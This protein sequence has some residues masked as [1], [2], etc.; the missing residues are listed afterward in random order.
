VTGLFHQT[1]SVRRKKAWMGSSIEWP[2]S[3]YL[4][5]L[6]L[7]WKAFQ[8]R[9]DQLVSS[10]LEA[11]KFY[12]NDDDYQLAHTFFDWGKLGNLLQTSLFEPRSPAFEFHSKGQCIIS[13]LF[14][15]Q[16]L[17]FFLQFLRNGQPT[18]FRHL[19]AIS[20]W[21]CQACLGSDPVSSAPSAEHSTCGMSFGL[22]HL[23]VW[24]SSSCCRSFLYKDDQSRQ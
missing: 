8:Y 13:W 21:V 23:A 18:V 5:C 2:P 9:F 4:C 6:W 16:L 10:R 19:I 24:C 15:H 7:L 1:A 14:W 22:R 11:R 3:W 20:F 17:A 12:V